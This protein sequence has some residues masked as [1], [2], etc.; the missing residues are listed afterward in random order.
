MG[1]FD[2]AVWRQVVGGALYRWAVLMELCGDRLCILL[3]L[4][5]DRMF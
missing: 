3:E 4:C 2:G 1:C 5:T